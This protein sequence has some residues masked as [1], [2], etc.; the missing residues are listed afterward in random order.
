MKKITLEITSELSGRKIE[1]VLEKRLCLSRTL[2][3]RLK[4]TSGAV[5]LNGEEP[6]LIRTVMA[7]DILTVNIA[8]KYTDGIARVKMKLDILFEDDVILAV[9]KSAGMAV[10]PSGN[11]KTD[12]LANGVMYHLG[13][14]AAF[15]VITRLD[16]E[17]SGVV[18]I[19]KDTHSAKL[20]TEEIKN[21]NI[22]KE[23]IALINGTPNPKEGQINA[24]IRKEEGRGI[25]RIVS[26]D[27]KEAL[28]FYEVIGNRKNLSVVRLNP[29]TGRTHQ[30]R[31]HLSYIGHPIYGDSMYGAPQKG[32][33][34]RLHCY[35]ISFVHPIT[36]KGIVIKTE[37]PDDIKSL[38]RN[39][40]GDV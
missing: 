37:V 32:E 35:K 23:Y 7:G 34:T 1:A 26:P 15:H 9:N 33:R 36:G 18:L 13:E 27:G 30:L 28:S 16:R 6:P 19:A 14:K 25:K 20:L 22:Q 4:R 24:P 2:I 39:L 12:T 10:H 29:V 17:T 11:H 38:I 5:L 21:G 40:G 3:A 31:L 8:E